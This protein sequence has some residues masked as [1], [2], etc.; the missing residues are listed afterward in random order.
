MKAGDLVIPMY[1]VWH[2]LGVVTSIDN[3]SKYCSVCF[4]M[5]AGRII[6]FLYAQL[7]VMNEKYEPHGDKR[8]PPRAK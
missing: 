4:P 2:G 8:Y 5:E 7:E 6:P 3:E 1:G